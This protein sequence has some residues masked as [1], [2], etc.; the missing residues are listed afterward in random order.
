MTHKS[1]ESTRQKYEASKNLNSKEN[2]RKK[3]SPKE[4]I[5]VLKM[6]RSKPR[7]WR[8]ETDF[9]NEVHRLLDNLTR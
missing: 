3:K 1:G 7:P 4:N 2:E 9:G 8:E 5:C 6:R